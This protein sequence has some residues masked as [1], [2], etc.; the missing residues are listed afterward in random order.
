MVSRP[1][2]A[3]DLPI[4]NLGL[5]RGKEKLGVRLLIIDDHP[6]V[7]S[8]CRAIFAAREDVE[9]LEVANGE[10]GIDAYFSLSADAA[11]IDINLPESR[12]WR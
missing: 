10:R 3:V 1:R 4:L 9:I 5:Q 2:P 12:A 7:I 6:V 8:G 11:L